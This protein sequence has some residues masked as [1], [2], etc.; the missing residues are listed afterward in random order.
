MS[1]F[2]ELKAAGSLMDESSVFGRSRKDRCGAL[3]ERPSLG[4]AD[5]VMAGCDARDV[6]PGMIDK[7]IRRHRSSTGRN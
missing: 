1:I 5:S 4:P 6:V 7:A 3:G 2:D